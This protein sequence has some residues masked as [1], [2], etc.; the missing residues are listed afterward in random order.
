MATAIHRLYFRA[1]FPIAS[2]VE[3][4]MGGM[5]GPVYPPFG[6]ASDR[7]DHSGKTQ[8]CAPEAAACPAQESILAR[9]ALRSVEAVIWQSATRTVVAGRKCGQAR[10]AVSTTA[11]RTNAPWM[12]QRRA[13][14]VPPPISCGVLRAEGRIALHFRT[15]GTAIFR[16]SP[17]SRRT[18]AYHEDFLLRFS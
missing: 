9:L 11:I 5:A 14:V 17:A 3:P 7:S 2:E 18:R 10:P 13:M 4:G 6:N 16:F 15:N 8:I 12:K 1:M